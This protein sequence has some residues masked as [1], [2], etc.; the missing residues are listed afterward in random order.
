MGIRILV[1]GDNRIVE[2]IAFCAGCDGSACLGQP[3]FLKRI[4]SDQLR[5]QIISL[6]KFRS[7]VSLFSSLLLLFG[8]WFDLQ[9]RR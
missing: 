1:V 8:R 7:R 3:I 6:K 9:I 5:E 4:A 2:T